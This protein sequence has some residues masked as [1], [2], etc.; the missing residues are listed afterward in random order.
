MC[1]CLSQTPYWGPGVQPAYVLTGNQTG[2]PLVP[3]PVLSPLSYTSQGPFSS[4]F[5]V[6]S[7]LSRVILTPPGGPNATKILPL[8][9]KERE[10]H[11]F[12]KL[13]ANSVNN[14]FLERDPFMFYLL[15]QPINRSKISSLL[16]TIF[17][18]SFS[19]I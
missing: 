12:Y 8:T 18:N 2:D 11:G 13:W 3:R 17:K 9:G 5:N 4:I 19:D 15:F 10:P 1:G 16:G 6:S 7:M 14:L